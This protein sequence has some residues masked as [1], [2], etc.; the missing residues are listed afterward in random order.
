MTIAEKLMQELDTK[1]GQAK[2]DKWIDEYIAREKIR[3]EKIKTLMSNSSYFKWLNQFTQD[4]EGFYDTDWLYDSESLT[5]IDKEN[6][7]KLSLFYDGI[8]QYAKPNYLY[9]TPCEFGD[10]YKIRLNEIGFEIGLL[11]GQ[12]AVSFCK[13]V[14]VEKEEEFIDLND[15][16]NGKKQE[17]V[18]KIMN[19]LSILSNMII[20]AYEDGVPCEAITDMFHRTMQQITIKKEGKVKTKHL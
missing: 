14:V 18:D 16:I 19:S 5:D 17:Q 12:G 3:S 13:R 2:L 6:V 11:V 8:A 10:F 4:K 7:E 20:A 9:P 1:E 15:I